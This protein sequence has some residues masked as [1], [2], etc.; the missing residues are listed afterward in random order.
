MELMGRDFDSLQR[1]GWTGSLG[2]TGWGSRDSLRQR[3]GVA[4]RCKWKKTSVVARL[5]MAPTHLTPHTCV[6]NLLMLC[7]SQDVVEIMGCG[8]QS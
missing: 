4:D 1:E 8:L 5:P 2:R 7:D 6:M 3:F